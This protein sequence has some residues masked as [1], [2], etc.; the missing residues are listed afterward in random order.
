VSHNGRLAAS[1]QRGDNSDVIVWD[2]ESKEAKFKLSEHDY[3]VVSVEF[4]F[5]DRLLVSCGNIQDKKIFVWDVSNG[6]VSRVL[7]LIGISS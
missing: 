3:E 1:G 7:T 4:S 2:Y 6:Y 5:D